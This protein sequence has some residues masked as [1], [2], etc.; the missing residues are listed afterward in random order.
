MPP[1]RIIWTISG[2]ELAQT[3]TLEDGQVIPQSEHEFT[4]PDLFTLLKEV[5]RMFDP[6]NIDYIQGLITKHV[7]DFDNPH[8]TDLAK[9][10]T[11]VL[12][13]L[14]NLWLS[15]GNSGT[16]EEFLKIL[17]QYVKIAD[18]TTALEGKALDQVPSVKAAAA[19][20]HQHDT[21]P[22]AHDA[23]FAKLFPGETVQLTPT[24]A[25]DALVGIPRKAIV[26]AE[27]PISYIDEHGVLRTAPA[28]V[29]PID[30]IYGDPAI[31]LTGQYTNKYLHSEQFGNAYW[32]TT[33]L[34]KAVSGNLQNLRKN[35]PLHILK[36]VASAN[37]VLHQIYPAV[38]LAVEKDKLYT[39]SVFVYP[40]D[41]HCFGIMLP[42]SYAGPYS[43]VHFDLLDERVF[44][45]AGSDQ[46]RI[47]GEIQKLHSGFYRVSMSFRPVASGMIKPA[48]YP[49]D[50]YDGDDNY[51][52]VAG[53]AIGIDAVQFNEGPLVPY[54][55]STDT[56]GA[57]GVH[58]FKIP[59]VGWLNNDEGTFVFECTNSG[60]LLPDINRVLYNLANGPT[61]LALSGQ[62]PTNHNRRFYFAANDPNNIAMYG[63]WSPPCTREFVSLVHAYSAQ[64]HIVAGFDGPV[65]EIV[66]TKP[67]RAD[68]SHLHIGA[69]RFGNS[70]FSGWFRRMWYYPGICTVKN[71]NFFLG[72]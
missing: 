41:R 65:Q 60:R 24:L 35:G 42:G 18:V 49:L 67:I 69:D 44:I 71:T 51:V 12:Q 6:A 66:V 32:K 29:L 33:N 52:G 38:E 2:F 11:S 13:E 25:V 59:T 1:I 68:S 26:T 50:I 39:I 36:E 14:Y 20:V 21:N 7:N 54:V 40:I 15:E 10:G 22:N 58:N 45:N 62:F 4:V 61:G 56:E 9:M 64:K 8:D 19:M 72:E 23:I 55:E 27:T 43:Y 47:Y 16:R 63:R 37:P 46:N 70:P 48:M 53:L 57:C 30:Y 28:G 31:P 34:V 3:D 17:F 5:R